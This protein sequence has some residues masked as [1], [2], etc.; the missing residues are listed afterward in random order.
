[1]ILLRNCPRV[2]TRLVPSVVPLTL[3]AGPTGAFVQR[4]ARE[5][6]AREARR[7]NK[8]QRPAASYPSPGRRGARGWG[9]GGEKHSLTLA[10]VIYTVTCVMRVFICTLGRRTLQCM[11]GILRARAR[12]R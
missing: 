8:P 11:R 6:P 9:T 7:D 3:F 2:I 4:F 5:K 12:A 10:Q 1:M